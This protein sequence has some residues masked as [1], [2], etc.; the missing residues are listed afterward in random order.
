MAVTMIDADFGE[1]LPNAKIKVP[2]LH[3]VVWH[4]KDGL[5]KPTWANPNFQEME[6]WLRDNCKQP[7]YHGGAWERTSFIEFECDEDAMMFALRW[8]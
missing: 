1:M 6:S 2:K 7:Y 4:V 5:M 8:I 3:K